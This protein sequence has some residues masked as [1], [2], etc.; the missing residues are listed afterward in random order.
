MG[1]AD[2]VPDLT[3][4]A[5]RALSAI[6][7]GLC[8][9]RD[10]GPEF[11]PSGVAHALPSCI[12]RNWTLGA[13]HSK[14]T[15]RGPMTSG[16]HTIG[17]SSRATKS[18]FSQCSLAV[19][20]FF[21]RLKRIA[22]HELRQPRDTH[23]D[24]RAS[25][26]F[27]CPTPHRHCRGRRCRPSHGRYQPRFAPRPACRDRGNDAGESHL[28]IPLVATRRDGFC[29]PLHVVCETARRGQPRGTIA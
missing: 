28:R 9:S 23:R 14:S 26:T 20:I 22:A 19:T 10:R 18:P 24:P 2:H 3:N 15:A 29:S 17:T 7:D 25:S 21:V 8:C 13:Y 16:D 5:Y 27:G 4:A 12:G 11:P 6:H 1:C